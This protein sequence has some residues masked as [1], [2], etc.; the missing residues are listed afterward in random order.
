V[1]ELR[2]EHPSV[3]VVLASR[4]ACD[5]FEAP[6]GATPMRIAPREL[7]LV[8]APDIAE[9][10]VPSGSDPWVEDVSDAWVALVLDGVDAPAAVARL[11]ELELPVDGWIQGEVAGAAA[12]VLVAGERV[13][14][15]VPAMLATHVEDRIRTDAAEVLGS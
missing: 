5:A 12:K 13:T 3:V 1:A 9:V 14:I 10:R 8:D 2:V 11:S 15:L 4:Q 6:D 7:M